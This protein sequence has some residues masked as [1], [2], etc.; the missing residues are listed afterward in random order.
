M[1]QETP[2]HSDPPR[3]AR[4]PLVAS[5]VSSGVIQA[6]RLSVIICT[7]I[8]LLGFALADA[9]TVRTAVIAYLAANG[10]TT[11]AAGAVS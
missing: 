4:W 10:V 6:L 7:A 1:T 3:R 5:F 2:Q 9:L 8:G 11:V